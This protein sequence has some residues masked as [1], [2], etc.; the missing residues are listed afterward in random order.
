MSVSSHIP[1]S[2]NTMPTQDLTGTVRKTES[3][4]FANGGLADIWKGEWTREGGS[5]EIVRHPPSDFALLKLI[6]T[7]LIG[8]H[9]SHPKCLETRRS[10]RK[11]QNGEFEPL[12]AS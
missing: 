10:F 7:E 2:T 12:N 3:H 11:A 4:Y 1:H 9:Q 6:L 8:R 5:R